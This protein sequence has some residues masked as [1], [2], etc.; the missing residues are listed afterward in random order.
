[1]SQWSGR[2]RGLEESFLVEDLDPRLPRVEVTGD[3][4][5][6]V[7]NHRGIVEYS[8]TM[9]RIALAG[10]ELRITGHDLELSA[11]TLTELTVSGRVCALEYIT[12]QG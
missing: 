12:L 9:M 11:L 7:E 1:M 8:D 3:R 6:H 10:S 2:L 5:V 4:R